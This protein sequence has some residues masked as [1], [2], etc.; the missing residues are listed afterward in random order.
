MVELE[1]PRF[2]RSRATINIAP[3][4]DVL[5]LLLIFF[6]VTSTFVEQPNIKL[7]LPRARHA[8]TTPLQRLVLVISRAGTF[9]LHDEPIKSEDLENRL[10]QE[11]ERTED[12]ALVL[13]AD[14]ATHYGSVIWAMDAARGAG[15]QK[16]VA[17]TLL[18]PLPSE[19]PGAASSR[20][21]TGRSS[22]RNSE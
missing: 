18:E 5:L 6:M 7:E 11:V 9:Y 20:Y 10:K 21:P 16:I 4:V 12:R 2:R 15:F 3:L 1:M 8:K 13:K 19:E 22:E 14:R 17:P